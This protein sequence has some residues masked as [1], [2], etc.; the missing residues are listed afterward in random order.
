MNQIGGGRS[1]RRGP[2][3][4]STP[5]GRRLNLLSTPHNSKVR[6]KDKDKEGKT[7]VKKK[8]KWNK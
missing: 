5:G 1:R 7:E 6:M 3:G 8:K 2:P 4:L